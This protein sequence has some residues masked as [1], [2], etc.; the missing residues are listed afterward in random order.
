LTFVDAKATDTMI[1]ETRIAK[2]NLPYLW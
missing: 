2:P 1:P